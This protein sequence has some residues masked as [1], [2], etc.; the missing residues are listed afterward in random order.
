M[1]LNSFKALSRRPSH[2]NR[3]QS[4]PRG[5]PNSVL[6]RSGTLLGC[7]WTQLGRLLGS[8]ERLLASLGSFSDAS[9]AIPRCSWPSIGWFGAPRGCILTSWVSPCLN[10]EGFGRVPCLVFG[11]FISPLRPENVSLQPRC[12]L[13]PRLYWGLC[14]SFLG[15]SVIMDPVVF[16]IIGHHVKIVCR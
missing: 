11:S 4:S 13:I 6:E 3:A 15:T 8:L 12:P 1:T 9:V 16:R 5:S 7:S 2:L 14:Q 10:F